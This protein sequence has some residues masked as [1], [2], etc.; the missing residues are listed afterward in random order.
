MEGRIEALVREKCQGLPVPV[1]R[2]L[3]SVFQQI[4]DV[5]F[6][7]SMPIDQVKTILSRIQFSNGDRYGDSHILEIKYSESDAGSNVFPDWKIVWSEEDPNEVH[8][9][10][11]IIGWIVRANRIDPILERRPKY[12]SRCQERKVV[13]RELNGQDI[14]LSVRDIVYMGA[15]GDF[16]R[17][18]HGHHGM[19]HSNLVDLSMKS[20][21]EMMS[22]LCFYRI[23][24]SYMVNLGCIR[25]I[26]T[27]SS[28]SH[29]VLCSGVQLPIARRRKVGLQEMRLQ[30]NMM[31]SHS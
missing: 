21:E 10:D 18:F 25:K 12:I 27:F 29:V 13:F 4:I 19:L 30:A 8:R 2:Y 5:E 15:E 26:Q 9:I 31:N 16:T 20:A 22:A 28:L 7:N 14:S 17:V 3:H 6:K 1:H 11:E 23:H 24:R